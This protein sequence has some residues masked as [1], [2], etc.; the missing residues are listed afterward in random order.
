VRRAGTEV[1]DPADDDDDDDAVMSGPVSI[2]S[3]AALANSSKNDL[4]RGSRPKTEVGRFAGVELT[5]IINMIDLESDGARPL[6][7]LNIG[8]SGAQRMPDTPT[9]PSNEMAA[10]M[11][12]TPRTFGG[13]PPPMQQPMPQRMPPAPMPQRMP[14]APMQPPPMQQPPMQQPP[15]QQPMQ[16]RPM[17]PYPAQ[18]QRPQQRPPVAGQRAVSTTKHKRRRSVIQPWVVIVAILLAAGIAA[19]IVALSGPSVTTHSK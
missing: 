12:T 18:Q 2:H 13:V 19:V 17:A 9:R 15:M 11:P 14:P 10:L 7:D 1:Y 16:Q 8:P 3:I 6:V 4:D 5:S